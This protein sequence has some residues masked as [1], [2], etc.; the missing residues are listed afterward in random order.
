MNGDIFLIQSCTTAPNGANGADGAI[1]SPICKTAPRGVVACFLNGASFLSICLKNIDKNVFAPCT[2][3]HRGAPWCNFEQS[4][5]LLRLLH[6][7][8]TP[9]LGGGAMVHGANDAA[10]GA[11]LLWVDCPWLVFILDSRKDGLT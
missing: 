3:L 7:C 11:V 4:V 10:G 2:F 8:T 6:H 1:K 5:V 9:P